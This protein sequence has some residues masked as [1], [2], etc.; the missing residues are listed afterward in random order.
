MLGLFRFRG[1][2][3]G[4]FF[5]GWRRKMGVVTLVMTVALTGLW[6]RCETIHD[7]ISFPIFD[8]QHAIYAVDGQI[9]WME[10]PQSGGIWLLA[11]EDSAIMTEIIMDIEK[12]W[13]A[14]IEISDYQKYRFRRLAVPA[15]SIVT[16]L[17]LLSAYLLLI[18]SRKQSPTVSYSNA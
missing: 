3:M 14:I 5:R 2:P 17:T 11:S 7:G 9:V 12:K 15:W 10:M 4:E 13:D 1:S 18:P 16:P 6:V 8:R